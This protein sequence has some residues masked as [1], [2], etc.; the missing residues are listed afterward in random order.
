MAKQSISL[1]HL[2]QLQ[3]TRI[4]STKSRYM[5][6]IIR[7]A[8]EIELHA[9]NMNKEDDFCLSWSWKPSS[10]LLKDVKKKTPQE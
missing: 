1:G 5:D 6:Q 7:E 4:L 8:T 9:N 3:D 10:T 2:I